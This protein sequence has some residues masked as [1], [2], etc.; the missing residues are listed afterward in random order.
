MWVRGGAGAWL[1]R[2]LLS[3]LRVI[4][5]SSLARSVALFVCAVF[6]GNLLIH[7]YNRT[8]SKSRGTRSIGGM[9]S[10][11]GWLPAAL[12]AAWAHDVGFSGM[13]LAAPLVALFGAA[14]TL[15]R[16]RRKVRAKT[17]TT[18]PVIGS[19]YTATLLAIC[20]TVEWGL[21]IHGLGPILVEAIKHS[22]ATPVLCVALVNTLLI[23]IVQ[24]LSS[25]RAGASV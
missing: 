2:G 23:G 5:W 21:Q 22:D 12:L 15:R 18:P 16:Q 17:A 20:L 3:A 8:A 4:P 14:L 7:W 1:D 24:Y 25:R 9:L 13:W 6:G 10:A 19:T 11:L